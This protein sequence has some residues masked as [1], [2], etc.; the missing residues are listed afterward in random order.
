MTKRI[1]PKCGEPNAYGKREQAE[2]AQ[3]VVPREQQ[4]RVVTVGQPAG[5]RGADQV[6]DADRREQRRR[7]H[8]AEPVIDRGRD[9]VRPDQAV[10][11]GAADEEA[12]GEQ[13]ERGRPPDVAEA[14]HRA[15]EGIAGSARGGGWISVAPYGARPR[16]AGRS[17]MK[18]SDERQDDDQR[19]RCRHP[20]RVPPAV[21]LHVHAS[22]GRKI[23]CPVAFAAVRMPVTSPRR[24]DEPAVRDQR[25]ERQRDRAGRGRVDDA[26]EQV[27]LPRR[28]PSRSSVPS[29]SRSRARATTI[30]RRRPKRS[31][32]AA[33]NGPPARSTIRLIEDGEA[34]RRA[35]PTELVLQRDDQDARRRAEAGGGDQRDEARRP[36]RPRRSGAAS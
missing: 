14:S 20:G 28:D 30:T 9:Q 36:A 12:S 34:D 15:R 7:G 10:R 2:P 8:L 1:S 11:R 25:R 33:A 16:S 18:S 31:A 23:S 32:N 19:D 6:E 17:R 22:S 35:A 27:E 21:V 3:P 26:P 13:P 29:R 24:C 4:T 5:A